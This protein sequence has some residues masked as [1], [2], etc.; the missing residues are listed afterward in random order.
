MVAISRN[1][2]DQELCC[3]P[4]ASSTHRAGQKMGC[5]MCRRRLF[6]AQTEIC[7]CHHSISTSHHRTTQAQWLMQL[8][9]DTETQINSPL[10]LS[11]PFQ[12]NNQMAAFGLL[13]PPPPPAL[14]SG[15]L[16]CSVIHP[17]TSTFRFVFTKQRLVKVLRI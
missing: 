11:F 4:W 6:S 12:A 14:I 9:D 13:F 2:P 5:G 17:I 16:N 3:V 8:E 1:T 10:P 7:R 15:K